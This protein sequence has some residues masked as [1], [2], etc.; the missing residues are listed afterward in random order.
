LKK[1]DNNKSIELNNHGF[2]LVET[3]V[4]VFMFISMVAAITMTLNA[5]RNSWDVNS[6]KIQ[7]QQSLR[8]A[9]ERIKE[10]LVEASSSSIVNVDSDDSWYTNII[11]R[12]PESVDVNGNITWPTDTTKY[13]LGGTNSEQLLRRIAEGEAHESEAVVTNNIKT[14]RF[15]RESANPDI[16][17]IDMVSEMKVGTGD[18]TSMNYEAKIQLRN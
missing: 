13:L 3:M 6:V 12:I 5:G 17:I 10:E 8:I 14:L 2:T 4:V 1:I 15:K 7:M 11:F 18:E 9:S 16:L